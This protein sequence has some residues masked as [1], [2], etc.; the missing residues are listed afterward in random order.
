MSLCIADQPP[1]F[2][3]AAFDS[4]ANLFVEQ[5]G[6][7]VYRFIYQRRIYLHVAYFSFFVAG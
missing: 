2:R 7:H 6:K 5:G 4:L 3:F 1:E